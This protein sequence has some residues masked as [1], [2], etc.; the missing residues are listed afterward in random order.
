MANPD[1]RRYVSHMSI[2]GFLY[3]RAFRDG[4]RAALLAVLA[5]LIASSWGCAGAVRLP[6]GPSYVP[7][8]PV[9]HAFGER[10]AAKPL[11]EMVLDY[12]VENARKRKRTAQ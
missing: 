9:S 10:A 12:L 1:E 6:D 2:R 11:D 7:A 8:E 4:R 5:G 3:M